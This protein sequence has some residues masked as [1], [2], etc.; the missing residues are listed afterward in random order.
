MQND[1]EQL[2]IKSSLESLKIIR[3][4]ISEF[5]IKRNIKK[6]S[7]DKIVLAVDEA[8]SNIIKHAYQLDESGIIN[9]KLSLEDSTLKIEIEDYGQPFKNSNVNEPNINDY[10]KEHKKGGWG[11][12][13]IKKIMNFVSYNRTNDGKNYLVLIKNVEFE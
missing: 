4:F 9:I 11:L 5:C 2:S 7:I 8:C 3:E 6:S 12:Y 10:Y 1:S 13:L